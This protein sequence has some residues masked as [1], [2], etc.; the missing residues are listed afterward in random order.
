MNLLRIWDIVCMGTIR[1]ACTW[2]VSEILIGYEEGTLEDLR[3]KT[4]E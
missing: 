1:W 2:V 3:R 4:A